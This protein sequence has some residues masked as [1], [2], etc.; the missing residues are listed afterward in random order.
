[1]AAGASW[2]RGLEV[3]RLKVG[4]KCRPVADRTGWTSDFK[5]ASTQFWRARGG[6]APATH[7]SWL[8]CRCSFVRAVS[9]PRPA[10]SSVSRLPAADSS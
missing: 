5:A 6:R 9:S 7:R 8:P 2:V 3:E 10:G 4:N 1:M